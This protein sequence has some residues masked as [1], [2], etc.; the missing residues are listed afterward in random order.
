MRDKITIYTI[1][2]EAGVSVSTVSRFLNGSANVS[3]EKRNAIENVVRKYNYRP[4][5]IA[6]NL[7]KQKTRMLGFILPDVTH[8]F[9]GT[10]FIEA[11]KRAMELGYTILL[12]NTMNDNMLNN[13]RME[14]RYIDILSEKLVDGVIMIG[15]HINEIDVPPGYIKKVNRLIESVPV[16]MINGEIEDLDCYRVVTRDELGIRALINHL[17]SLNHEKIGFVGGALGI[18]PTNKRLEA[19]KRGLAVHGI[20]FKEEWFVGSGFNIDT[21]I[22]AFEQILQM[23]DRPTAV[24]C[25]NDLV[26]I[27]IIHSAI[28]F[29]LSI[30]QDLSVAG[31]DNIYLTEYMIPR[32]TTVDLNLKKLGR[33]AVDTLVQCLNGKS[34]EKTTVVETRLVIRDSC[35]NARNGQ[36]FGIF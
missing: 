28:K 2:R 20:E 19:V 10:T 29:G 17:I 3:E 34:P 15:G 16:V 33:M 11:E 36:K 35:I 25:I 32:V 6:R 5:A 24:V 8:P 12:C 14:E 27:G 21:G 18:Q 13:T 7:S 22:E 30:P 1:A 9:Y 26:A 23:D 31:F 4:N